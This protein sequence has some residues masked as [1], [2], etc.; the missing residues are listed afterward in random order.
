M[1]RVGRANRDLDLTVL[2]SSTSGW[3]TRAARGRAASRPRASAAARAEGKRLTNDVTNDCGS[4]ARA[5][6]RT[7]PE[8]IGGE[9]SKCNIINSVALLH[10]FTRIDTS[11]EH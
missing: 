4:R 2:L 5:P 10:L 8:R 9:F 7:G 1:E 6:D 3:W 11:R